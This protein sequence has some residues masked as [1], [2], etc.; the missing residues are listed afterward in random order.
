MIQSLIRYDLTDNIPEDVIHRFLFEVSGGS[1]LYG[2]I[3]RSEVKVAAFS[4][5]GLVGFISGD[6]FNRLISVH[7]FYVKGE[8]RAEGIGRRLLYH[9]IIKAKREGLDGVDIDDMQFPSVALLRRVKERCKNNS[10]LSIG[11]LWGEEAVYG[12]IRFRGV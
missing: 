8:R 6:Y 3:V 7:G 11:E 9:T 4:E 12:E 1:S 10:W 2:E 5:E